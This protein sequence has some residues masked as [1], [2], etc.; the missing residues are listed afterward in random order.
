MSRVLM[1]RYNYDDI[2]VRQ[3][4]EDKHLYKVTSGKVAAYL[5]HGEPDEILIGI[6][7]APACFGELSLLLGQPSPYT[8]IAMSDAA[9][10][11]IPEDK[12]ESFVEGNPRNSIEIMRTMS[13]QQSMINLNMSMMA[14]ELMELARSGSLDKKA[15]TR[16]VERYGR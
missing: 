3:G 2:I 6:I 8:Y 1:K 12:F 7:S 11:C 9:A 14:E 5:N 16:L 4:S 10:L 13:R 15:V